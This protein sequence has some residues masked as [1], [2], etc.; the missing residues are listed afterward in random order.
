MPRLSGFSLIELL[1]ALALVAILSAIAYPAYH[2][3]V[4]K[5]RRAGAK[6]ELMDLAARLEQY[7]LIHHIVGNLA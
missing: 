6:V 2:H 1:I 5:T 3:H 7:R 4:I